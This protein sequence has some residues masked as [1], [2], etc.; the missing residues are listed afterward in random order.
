MGARAGRGRAAH[1]PQ[2]ET[3]LLISSTLEAID[4][5]HWPRTEAEFYLLRSAMVAAQAIARAM[6]AAGRGD[7]IADIART[8]SRVTPELPPETSN[9]DNA[10]PVSHDDDA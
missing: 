8:I 3:R 5:A 4:G 2:F 1:R 9:S 6:E 7:E 10:F